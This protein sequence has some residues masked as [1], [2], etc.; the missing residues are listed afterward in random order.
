MIEVDVRRIL[1]FI[2]V[3]FMAMVAVMVDNTQA[4][5]PLPKF[6]RHETIPADN[7]ARFILLEEV[8]L[9]EITVIPQNK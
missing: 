7:I 8:Y 3:K 1:S 4:L 5:I 6:L 2:A 9:D